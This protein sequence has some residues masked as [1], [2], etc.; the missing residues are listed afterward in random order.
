MQK[1][2]QFESEYPYSF[3]YSWSLIVCQVAEG[4]FENSVI[5]YGHVTCQVPIVPRV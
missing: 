2:A 3:A 5:E 4:G 1:P